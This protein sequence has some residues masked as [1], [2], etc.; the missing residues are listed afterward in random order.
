MYEVWDQSGPG[1]P[2]VGSETES[3]LNMPGALGGSPDGQDVKDAG[4][5]PGCVLKY[6]PDLK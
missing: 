5:H 6:A 4:P 3:D 2:G 1:W